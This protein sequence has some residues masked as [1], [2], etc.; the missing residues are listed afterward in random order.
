MMTNQQ[1]KKEKK[2]CARTNEKSKVE[3]AVCLFCWQHCKKRY[4]RVRQLKIAVGVFT[5]TAF[6]C[7]VA[8]QTLA[9]KGQQAR[10]QAG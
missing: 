6:V 4:V 5:E 3:L 8:V 7:R 2:A 10:C 9:W 1:R